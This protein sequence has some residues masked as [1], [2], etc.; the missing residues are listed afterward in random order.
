MGDLQ[1]VEDEKFH[2]IYE[3]GLQRSNP[4][5]VAFFNIKGFVNQKLMNRRNRYEN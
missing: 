2:I 3:S 4:F 5:L 1:N